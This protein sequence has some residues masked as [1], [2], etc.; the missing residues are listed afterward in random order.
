MTVDEPGSHPERLLAAEVQLEARSDH[1]QLAESAGLELAHA[2][3]GDA[4]VGPDLLERLR[5]L[6][7]EAEPPREHVAHPR[8]EATQCLGELG[9]LEHRRSRGI[10]AGGVRVLDQ[11][12]VEALAVADGRL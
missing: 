6:A 1:P 7:V 11:V 3:A 4:E 9:G 8:R 2:L 5:G 12:A 10:R